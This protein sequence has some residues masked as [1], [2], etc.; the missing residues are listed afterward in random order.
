MASYVIGD[1]QGCFETFLSL[2]NLINFNHDADQAILL[3]DVI[4]RGPQSLEVLRFVRKHEKSINIVLGNHE[5]YAIALALG[6]QEGTK[7]TLHALLEAHDASD[8]FHWLRRQPLVIK[9]DQVLCVHAGIYPNLSIN[10]ALNY[11]ERVHDILVSHHAKEFLSNYFSHKII[12]PK[13]C[14]TPDE[15]ARFYLASFTLMR[16]CNF[17]GTLDLSFSGVPADAAYGCSPWFMLRPDDRQEIF[18]GHWAALGLHRY[19]NYYCLD[20]GCGWG[21]PLSALR[22]EDYQLFQVDNCEINN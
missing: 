8:I 14:K 4:N 12:T 1:I 17:D 6:A 7:H 15:Q 11:G 19:K 3:G 9:K 20:S 5:I 16:T 13:L 22:L 2:L 18:F 21:K 10:E